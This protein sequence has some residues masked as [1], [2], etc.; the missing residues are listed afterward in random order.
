[1][2]LVKPYSL[3]FRWCILIKIAIR[4]FVGIG[5]IIFYLVG[6]YPVW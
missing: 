5:E 3:D 6:I 2:S 1:M 4:L